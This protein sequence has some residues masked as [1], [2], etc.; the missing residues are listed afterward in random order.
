ML[1]SRKHRAPHASTHGRDCS[2]RAISGYFT[3]TDGNSSNPPRSRW[4]LAANSIGC[5][6]AM[7]RATGACRSKFRHRGDQLTG[8]SSGTRPCCSATVNS[9]HIQ[10]IASAAR[11]SISCPR[12]RPA[13]V[14]VFSRLWSGSRWARMCR[15]MPATVTLAKCELASD[16]P[17]A[18]CRAGGC[19]ACAFKPAWIASRRP[20]GQRTWQP[21]PGQRGRHHFN[22]PSI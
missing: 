16:T 18:D 21:Q 13:Q 17:G 1:A 5:E 12:C 14:R 3:R 22:P 9:R 11:C 8:T 7:A 2:R 15:L 20:R 4:S 19:C 6:A 10:R